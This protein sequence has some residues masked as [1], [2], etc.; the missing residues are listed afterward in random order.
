MQC[1][2]VYAALTHSRCSLMKHFFLSLARS[3][4]RKFHFKRENNNNNKKKN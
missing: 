3:L 1:L 2:A 4:F